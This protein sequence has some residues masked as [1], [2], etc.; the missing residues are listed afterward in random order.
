MS[1]IIVG[2]SVIK[3]GSKIVAVPLT[4]SAEVTQADPDKVAITFDQALLDTSV[5]ATTAFALAGKTISNVAIVGAVVTLTVTV[6]YEYG[7]TITV[8][9]TKPGANQLKAL[10]GGGQVASFS[11]QVVTNNITHP[12]AIEDG[13]TK[14]WLDYMT[15][16]TKD[17]SNGVSVWANKLLVTASDLDHIGPTKPLWESDG[18]LFDGDFD[19]MWSDAFPY[20]QPE[21]IYL[22]IKQITWSDYGFF[23]DGIP[24]NTGVVEQ[25]TGTVSPNIVAYAGTESTPSGALALDTWGIVRVLFN[26]ASSKLIVN[27]EIPITGNFGALDMNGVTLAKFGSGAYNGHIKIAEA[28][29]RQVD[30]AAGDE[31]LIYNYLKSKYGL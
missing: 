13:N 30:E 21:M 23:F 31:A 19:G 3:Y 5:P 12:L 9:Y 17:G 15:G 11:G 14:L 26:G 6:T 29:F 28:I 25:A 20:E 4:V 16:V 22:V 10:I 18:I 7:D 24:G 1:W 8:D 2:N 27:N